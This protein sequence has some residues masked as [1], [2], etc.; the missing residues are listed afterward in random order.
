MQSGQAHVLGAA[1]RDGL[2]AGGF[3]D[4][5]YIGSRG[6]SLRPDLAGLN[7]ATR[8]AALI[9]CAN[10][11]NPAEA[12][13]VSSASGRQRY[14]TAIRKGSSVPRVVITARV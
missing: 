4:S 3:P 6:I 2:S 10:M 8:P 14:A 12:A 13:V 7:L 11:R 1:L 9:E 5:T